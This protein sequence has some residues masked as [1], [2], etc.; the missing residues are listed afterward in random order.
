MNESMRDFTVDMEGR[1][2]KAL[3]EGGG[4]DVTKKKYGFDTS[5]AKNYAEFMTDDHMLG[6]HKDTMAF[7]RKMNK[8]QYEA[9]KY[10]K[11]N[12][13]ISKDLDS[14]SSSSLPK[15][16]ARNSATMRNRH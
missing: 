9:E 6:I 10:M 5:G 1:L 13:V 3:K 12:P 2:E 7:N 16:E 15:I 14:V 8:M 11:K 4:K